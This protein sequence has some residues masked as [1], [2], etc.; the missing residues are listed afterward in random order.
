M[1]L[2]KTMGAGEEVGRT[3]SA[4]EGTGSLGSARGDHCVKKMVE[5]KQGGMWR[6]VENGAIYIVF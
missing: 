4:S 3:V 5:G 6:K 2:E 1:V